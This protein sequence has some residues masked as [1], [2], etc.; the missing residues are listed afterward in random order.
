[1][2]M[3]IYDRE[4][5]RREGPGF[6]ASITQ[7]GR[8]CKWLIA[9]NIVMFVLQLATTPRSQPSID[10]IS[11]D[12]NGRPVYVSKPTASFTDLFIMNAEEV[13]H[14]QVWR[15]LTY[16][17]L[18]DTNGFWH[19]LF[20]ML[21][22]W[23]FGSTVEDLYGPWEFLTFYLVA[24]VLGGIAFQLTWLTMG[25]SGLCLG[26]SGAV[27]AVLVLFAFH[28]PRN[29]I[30]IFGLVPIPIW[31]FVLFSVG[32]DLF[33]FLNGNTGRTA[34]T[35]HLAGAA[36]GYLYYKSNVR[37]WNLVPDLSNFG[38]LRSRPRLRVYREEPSRPAVAG[39]PSGNANNEHLE[40]QLDAVLEKV[41]RYGRSSL[42]ESE[43]N[44]L[45]RASEIYKRRRT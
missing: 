25:G 28:Y 33:H 40:A 8:V 9:V 35:V 34:V 13:L 22:L 6:L 1:M 44:I 17:F 29:V 24:A 36:F 12:E 7:H 5:Y 10:D 32:Q 16:A 30:Y 14:G 2:A 18:H 42:T 15:L 31:I 21:F 45:Q 20:N 26:A 4:Y 27:T 11:F 39:A 38:K 19:I 3:G 41:A 43:N 23:W 37:L